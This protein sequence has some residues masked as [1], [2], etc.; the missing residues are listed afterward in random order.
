M[1]TVKQEIGGID[2][3]LLCDPCLLENAKVNAKG[4]C[5]QCVE[6]VCT[7]CSRQHIKNKCTRFHTILTDSDIPQ[8]KALFRLMNDLAICPSHIN[9][10]VSHRCG[11]HNAYMCAVCIAN[12]HR[13]CVKVEK[14]SSISLHDCKLKAEQVIN[15]FKVFSEATELVRSRKLAHADAI[16]AQSVQIEN[17]RIKLVR[18]LNDKISKLN[19]KLAEDIENVFERE[20]TKL[21][22]EYARL[23][24]MQTHVA[25]TRELVQISLKYFTEGH[26]SVVRA[27]LAKQ[28]NLDNNFENKDHK[29]NI[30]TRLI[31]NPSL[32]N[33]HSLGSIK[34]IKESSPFETNIENSRELYKNVAHTCENEDTA[35]QG[36]TITESV[37]DMMSTGTIIIT[38]AE[39]D[40]RKN[41]LE[42]LN[43]TKELIATNYNDKETADCHTMLSTLDPPLWSESGMVKQT[44]TTQCVSTSSDT[45][46]CSVVALNILR[47]GKLVIID[48]S[49]R[50]IKVFDNSLTLC[51]QYSLEGTPTDMCIADK[52]RLVLIFSDILRVNRY[53]LQDSIIKSDKGFPTKYQSL[54]IAGFDDKLVILVQLRNDRKQLELRDISGKIVDIRDLNANCMK[55]W[56]NIRN[57]TV[58]LYFLTKERIECCCM[59][60]GNHLNKL[61]NKWTFKM[62]SE[63]RVIDVF[64]A[65]VDLDG[66]VYLLGQV[67]NK[68]D[69]QEHLN[70][71]PTSDRTF[72]N[73]STY[74]MGQEGT[75][76]ILGL[77]SDNVNNIDHVTSVNTCKNNV[78]VPN[79]SRPCSVTRNSKNHELIIGCMESNDIFLHE[80]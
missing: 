79:I 50:K 32:R 75:V 78:I 35:I 39:A 25:R 4:F 64:A 47:D 7:I 15:Q 22:N 29:C 65:D 41:S 10:T 33:L 2:C 52:D 44:R 45:K 54:S 8:N 42:S 70:C 72:L 12:Y 60:Q 59:Q 14:L 76:Y 31:I 5:V 68:V 55:L 77:T 17:E 61:K 71:K 40:M 58:H 24:E 63:K 11:D 49:N 62:V 27:K 26:L 36:R 16:Q 46:T 80:Y 28:I 53:I 9:S 38:S 13:A 20:L 56:A 43:P 19:E 18:T 6:Y 3:D 67:S 37:K 21:H 66:N 1:A 73:I 69:Q 51:C 74:K 23:I 57:T 30:N 34:V 48:K